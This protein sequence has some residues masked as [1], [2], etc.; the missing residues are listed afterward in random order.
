MRHERPI[1]VLGGTGKTGRRVAERL[2]ARGFAVRLGSRTGA[3]PRFEWGDMRSWSAVLQGTAAVYITYQPDLAVP[4]A[5][6]AVRAFA[7]LALKLGV[8]RM[9]LLSGRGES[10][11]QRAEQALKDSGADWTI[12]RASWFAQNFSESFLL[13]ALL[14]D[15]IALPAGAIG[16]PFIDIDD[17]ADVVVAALTEDHHVGR[18][19]EVSGPRLLTFAEAVGEIAAVSGRRIRYREISP[20]E[21]AEQLARNGV[22]SDHVSLVTYLFTTVLD[23]RNAVV[24]DGV[25]R[26]LGRAPRDFGVYA[27][28]TAAAGVWAPT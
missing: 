13:D 14:S 28:E 25:R 16:E 6:E 17:I 11:A 12:V 15:E 9:V 20:Q 2:K 3:A 23:G 24:T 4:G 1:L 21:Y 8:R 27:R 22:S 19:Y 10:E 7:D 26:A 18:T 5:V